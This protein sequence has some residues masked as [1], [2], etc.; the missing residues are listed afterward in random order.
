MGLHC[1]ELEFY[2]WRRCYFTYGWSIKDSWYV[3]R[4]REGINIYKLLSVVEGPVTGHPYTSLKWMTWQHW[5]V[6]GNWRVPHARGVY[7][8]CM[9]HRSHQSMSFIYKVT[10]KRMPLRPWVLNWRWVQQLSPP[11]LYLTSEG[12]NSPRWLL[13]FIVLWSG[14]GRSGSWRPCNMVSR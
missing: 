6:R 12:S 7:H 14:T 11:A 2:Q 13:N 8:W 4:Q 3:A 9:L 5:H 10:I 1:S